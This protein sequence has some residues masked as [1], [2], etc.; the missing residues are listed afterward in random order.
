M[1]GLIGCLAAAGMWTLTAEQHERSTAPS[2]N[3]EAVATTATRYPWLDRGQRAQEVE[4]VQ[5][6]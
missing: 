6:R 3:T 2:P 1:A 4:H 5:S